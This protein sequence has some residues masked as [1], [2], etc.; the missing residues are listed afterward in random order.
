[1]PAILGTGNFNL[2]RDCQIVLVGPFGQVTIPNVTKFGAKQ[3]TAT[4]KVDRL[5]GVQLNTELPKGCPLLSKPSGQMRHLMRFLLRLRLVG[6]IAAQWLSRRYT[7]I[8][9]RYQAAAL[10][11][12]TTFL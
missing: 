6:I 9:P 7:S 8:S 11:R 4:V 12:W 5:D 10:I 1:M 3:E 2:G